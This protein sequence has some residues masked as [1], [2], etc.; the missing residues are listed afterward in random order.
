MLL[1]SIMMVLSGIPKEK[2]LTLILQTIQISLAAVGSL[3]LGS[4]SGAINNLSACV[5][6]ILSYNGKLQT[7][8]KTILIVCTTGFTLLLND[9]GIIGLLPLATSILFILFMNTK[10]M[11]KFSILTISTM[12]LWVIHDFYIGAYTSAIFSIVSISTNIVRIIRI[13]REKKDRE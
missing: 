6:N 12:V 2:K 1:A 11:V 3:V 9:L 8:A 4:F 5:R 10:D 7:V 13:K